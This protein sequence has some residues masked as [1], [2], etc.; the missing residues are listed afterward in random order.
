MKIKNA[1]TAIYISLFTILFIITGGIIYFQVTKVVKSELEESQ[2][3]I[4][5]GK[6]EAISFYMKGLINEMTAISEN[7]ILQ[8]GNRDEIVEFLAKNVKEKN[9]RYDN[10]TFLSLDGKGIRFDGQLVEVSDRDY[11][12]EII[13]QGKGYVI[14]RPLIS[15]TSGKAVFVISCMVKNDLGENI[16]ILNNNVLL[17]TI[18][19]I[20]NVKVGKSGY[21][22]IIDDE[23]TVLAHPQEEF[24][25]KLNYK[26]VEDMKKFV[27]AIISQEKFYVETKNSLKG[28]I[29]TMR[30]KKIPNTPGWTFGITVPKKEIYEESDKIALLILLIIPISLLIVSTISYMVAKKIASPITLAANFANRMAQ[31]KYDGY[32]EK[33]FTNRKDEIGTLSKSFNSLVGSMVDIVTE[34]KRSSE[35]VA[36]SSTEMSSQMVLV[37]EGAMS[38]NEKKTELEKDFIDMEQKMSIITDNVRTQVAGMEEISST[39]AVMA[40]TVKN[41]A[42]N[43]EDTMKISVEASKAAIE[44]TRVVRETLEGMKDIDEITK[45]IDANIV[46]IYSISDQTNLLALNAAIEAARAGEAGKG[47]AVV[48]DE[49]RKLAETSNKF[50]EIISELVN[51]MRAKVQNNIGNSNLAE[52]KLQEINIKVENTN[53]KIEK[54]SKA[55]EEQAESTKEVAEVIHNLSEASTDIEMQAEEQKELLNRGKIALD[56]IAEVIEHQ[57]ASTEEMSAASEEL[58]GLAEI[59]DEIVRKFDISAGRMK[60]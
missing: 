27:D 31:H 23:T 54:V 17:D 36:S 43:A 44:G 47:F 58:A 57:T 51:E 48:A 1:I 50:T 56:K 26:N 41:V 29:V 21:A 16:G 39:I 3:K 53:Q 18:S 11:F 22:W 28:F 20:S 59:L 9:E 7:K 34:L 32:I 33:S 10:L 19:N 4:L 49:I 38:Q 45:K 5:E 30:T 40:D 46:S 15:K 24:R 42:E 13:K 52:E 25:M 8:S 2:E 60:G 12:Q 6:T 14:S 37:A 35:N 55:M